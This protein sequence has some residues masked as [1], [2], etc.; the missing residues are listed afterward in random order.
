MVG[1]FY[2]TATENRSGNKNSSSG[3]PVVPTQRDRTGYL[4]P[5]SVSMANV[6]AGLRSR[7]TMATSQR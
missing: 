5:A 4:I 6:E 2:M 3:F 1:E 7:V